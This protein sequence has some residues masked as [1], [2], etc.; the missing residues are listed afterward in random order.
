MT[1]TPRN[2][3][4]QSSLSLAINWPAHDVSGEDAASA[5]AEQITAAF[6]KHYRRRR[7]GAVQIKKENLYK[8]QEAYV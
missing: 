5:W 7:F 2:L 6:Q 1:Q 8:E 3:T 4:S